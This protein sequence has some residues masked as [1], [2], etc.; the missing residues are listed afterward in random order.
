MA[1]ADGGVVDLGQRWTD[2]WW[3]GGSS[4]DLGMA[5]A[6]MVGFGGR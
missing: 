2:L 3:R 5:E 4:M 1:I 6:E